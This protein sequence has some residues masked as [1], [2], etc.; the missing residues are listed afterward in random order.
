MAKKNASTLRLANLRRVDLAFDTLS[1]KTQKQVKFLL[2]QEDQ[3]TLAQA[4]KNDES[5]LLGME[6]VDVVDDSG[7]AK[8]Q[9]FLFGPSD[10]Y[11]LGADSTKAIAEIPQHD[12]LLLEFDP[13]L[14]AQFEAAW[15]EGAK[16]LKI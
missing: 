4:R 8:Y 14:H 13:P 5:I 15:K 12:F 11:V 6:V 16:R 2:K 3:E 1:P 10:G 7:T 9:M